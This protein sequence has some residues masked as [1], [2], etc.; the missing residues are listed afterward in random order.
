MNREYIR[1]KMTEFVNGIDNQ[2]A[3]TM[4]SHEKDFVSAYQGHM[5]KVKSE[6]LFLK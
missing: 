1:A 2:F 5:T 4:G 3:F 6:L